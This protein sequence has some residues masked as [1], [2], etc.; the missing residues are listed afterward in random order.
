M[1]Q[2]SWLE[3]RLDGHAQEELDLIEEALFLAGALS[4]SYE[5]YDDEELFEPPLGTTPLWQKTSIIAL[6]AQDSDLNEILSALHQMLG[7]TLR[8]SPRFFADQEWVRAWLD[9]F[10]PIRFGH[11]KPYFYVA[12]SEHHIE[13]QDAIV[14]RL[15]PGLAFGTGTHPSTAMCLNHL[16]THQPYASLYDYGCGSGILGIAASLLGTQSVYQT[17]IDPQALQ[18][19]RENALKN[20]VQNI[21]I[22]E[23]AD[24]APKVDCIMAN[25]L[26]E[27]LCF[28]REQFEKHMHEDTVL[29]F[30]GL[31][32]RQEEALRSAYLG[33]R[34]EKI[35]EHEGWIC[36][37]LQR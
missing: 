18:A 23:H 22:L 25:I 19:S 12:A 13:D 20:H 26:L 3:L 27:P 36:L 35:D 29:I 4:V 16:A 7:E 6:F 24:D 28:L 10:K 34:I 2:E 31:L 32:A 17:D 8:F 15:D 5:A 11:Q 30:S 33:Y 14:L 1:E 37:K 9:Y 21:H